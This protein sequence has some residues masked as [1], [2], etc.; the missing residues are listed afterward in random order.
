MSNQNI[1]NDHSLNEQFWSTGFVK[2]PMFSPTE[3]LQLLQINSRLDGHFSTS[4]TTS[5]WSNN[6]SYRKAVLDQIKPIFDFAQK[7]WLA[8]FKLVMATILTKQPS[9]DSALDIHQD[10]AFTDEEKHVA[11]NIWV[12]LQ[13][14]T[15]EN[16]PLYLLPKSHLFAAPYRGR[17]I[18]PQFNLVKPLIAQRSVPILAK[19]GEAIIFNV[20]ML[21]F[22]SAN[23][24]PSPRIAMA[25][26]GIPQEATLLHYINY[27]PEKNT[28]TKLEVD[29]SFYNQYAHNDFIPKLTNSSDFEF[30]RIQLDSDSFLSLYHNFNP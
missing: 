14:I 16:G 10:W 2:V 19:A 25:M 30:E 1:F 7:K 11:V 9:H 20:R 8:D 18:T 21:H 24:T 3:V 29:D 23:L 22:S 6:A 17:H 13:D 4:F 28:L 27:H 15:L 12:P 26:V 5:I